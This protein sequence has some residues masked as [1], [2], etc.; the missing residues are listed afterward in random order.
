VLL[1]AARV[2]KSQ[3]RELHL[4]FFNQL[5]NFTGCHEASGKG[6]ELADA[7]SLIVAGEVAWHCRGCASIIRT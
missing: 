4:F 2:R 6:V 7:F 5:Q 1:F 3:V